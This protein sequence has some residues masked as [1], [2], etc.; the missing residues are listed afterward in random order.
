MMRRMR[1]LFGS[2][3]VIVFHGTCGG[4]PVAT[5]PNIDSLC[6]VTLC[7]E[8]IPFTSL[9][10]AYVQYQVRKYGIS[11]TVALWKPGEH[12]ESITDEDIIDAMF[13]MNGRG[14]ALA[15]VTASV[16]ANNK[17]VWRTHFGAL[18]DYYIT[19]LKALESQSIKDKS[20]RISSGDKK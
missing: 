20:G 2:D 10:D 8:N 14:R 6:D 17:Y 5:V 16:P 7:G 13:S 9:D 11:N 19:K 3:G 4:G 12:P 15:Y 1:A 18:Y